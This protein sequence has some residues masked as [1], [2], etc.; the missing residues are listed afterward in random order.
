MSGLDCLDSV[1]YGQHMARPK[2][3]STAA[4]NVL[5]NL[6]ITGNAAIITQQLDRKLYQEVNAALEALGGKW[7]RK[8][9]AHLFEGDPRDAIEQVVVDGEFTD[10]KREFEFFATPVPVA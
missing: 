9:K 10:E 3:L 2:K 1:Y 5:D 7:N 4:I 8:A 6:Q